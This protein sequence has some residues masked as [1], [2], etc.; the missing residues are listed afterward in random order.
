MGQDVLI[1]PTVTAGSCT[2]PG[3][4]IQ[5]SPAEGIGR[6][7][8]GALAILVHVAFVALLL[9]SLAWGFAFLGVSL[10]VAIGIAAL[11]RGMRKAP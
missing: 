10:C 8:A 3:H 9:L 1:L 2:N 7:T 4:D 5:V 11:Y 6:I